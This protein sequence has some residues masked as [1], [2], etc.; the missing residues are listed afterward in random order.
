MKHGSFTKVCYLEAA[1]LVHCPP[2]WR[3]LFRSN[4]RSIIHHI[5]AQTTAL[6]SGCFS[7]ICSNILRLAG[8]ASGFLP[9]PS[10]A[11]QRCDSESPPGLRPLPHPVSMLELLP[12]PSPAILLTKSMSRS[13]ASAYFLQLRRQLGIT[14]LVEI[15]KMRPTL[16][17][18]CT[19][20]SRARL[21][22]AGGL[23]HYSD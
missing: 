5:L 3:R 15:A 14:D 4:R 16:P 7:Y 10:T 19:G 12:H 23:H 8:P 2:I 17:S 13:A 6:L 21:R 20:E 1:K 11:T 9:S 22:L 18:A